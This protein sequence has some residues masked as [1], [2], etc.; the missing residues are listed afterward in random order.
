M[1][2]ALIL[3]IFDAINHHD[4]GALARCLPNDEI[5]GGFERM[6]AA[7]PD[8]HVAVDLAAA[9]GELVCTKGTI[10]GTHTGRWRKFDGSG[11]RVNVSY[12]D[13]WR[14]QDGVVV[15]NWVELDT[16]ALLPNG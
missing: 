15:G 12:L 2:K 3:Q 7:I 11:N 4:A 8:V 10:S 6:M 5:R 13:M 14:I 1:N 16:F 9:E